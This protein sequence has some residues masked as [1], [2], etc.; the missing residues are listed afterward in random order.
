[1]PSSRSYSDFILDQLS[2][3]EGISRRSMM[4]ET[5]VYCRG[6]IVGGVYDDRFLVKPTA[7]AAALM[8]GAAREAPYPGARE[9][10]VVEN[11]DDRP[12]LETLVTA[13]YD[14]LP[15]PKRRR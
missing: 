10:L 8:P 2:G 7:S 14:E 5:I 11:V 12:F 15:E 4:G 6:K 13:V 1:M 3:L 9:M